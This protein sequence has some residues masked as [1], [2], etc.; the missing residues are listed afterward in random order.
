MH[1]GGMYTGC[2]CVTER[3]PP[4]DRIAQAGRLLLHRQELRKG[5]EGGL[6]L[7]I[8]TSTISPHAPA[9]EWVRKIEL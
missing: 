6:S 4:R 5:S 2:I 1:T 3:L 9:P 8:T 7:C